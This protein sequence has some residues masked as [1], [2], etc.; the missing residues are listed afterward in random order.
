[1]ADENMDTGPGSPTPRPDV[2]EIGMVRYLCEC[3]NEVIVY[4]MHYV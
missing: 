3:Q 4:C 1:M 2:D